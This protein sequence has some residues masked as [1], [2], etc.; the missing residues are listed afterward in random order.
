MTSAVS[1]KVVKKAVYIKQYNSA[2]ALGS[3]DSY[4]FFFVKVRKLVEVGAI[5][6]SGMEFQA[7]EY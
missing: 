1:P 3:L 4:L 5:L 7:M 2:N 6:F